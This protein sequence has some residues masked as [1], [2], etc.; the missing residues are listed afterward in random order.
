MLCVFFLLMVL[1]MIGFGLIV[2]GIVLYVNC[3]YMVGDY[4]LLGVV[5]VV[6][7]VFVVFVIW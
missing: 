6:V 7:V 4:L 3:V 5:L 2:V 1:L